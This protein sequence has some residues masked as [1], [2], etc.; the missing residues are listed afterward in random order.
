MKYADV[1]V[2]Y[3]VEGSFTYRVPEGMD[4]FPG[5][6]AR[7]NFK[8]RTVTAFVH[9]V[10]GE[11][12]A[13]KTKDIQSLIDPAPIFDE[14]FTA[15]CA[16]V[17]DNYFSS[18]GEAM[19][20]AL[21]S[22]QRP[23][24]RHE[25][26]AGVSAGALVLTE[27]QQAACDAIF[28]ARDTGER[29]HLVFGV[30]GSGKTE[31]Y[32]AL[33]RRVMDEGKSVIYLVPEISLSS[34]VFT[35][36]RGMFG[37]E[38]IVYHSMLTAN[39]RLHNWLK[40]M[41]GEARI[42]VGTRSAV[43]LQAPDLGLLII[44]EEHD[45]SYKEHSSPRYNARR[46]AFR[47]ARDEGALLV[48]GSATPSV[49]SLYAA[50]R[51]MMRLHMLRKRYGGATLPNIEIARLE[52]LS[53]SKMLSTPLLLGTTKALDE[54]GQAIFFLNRRG[55]A[56]FL[57]CAGCGAVQECPHCSISLNFHRDETLRC[58]YCGHSRRVPEV[59]P[60]C[61][62][63]KLEK[64]GTGTQRLEHAVEKAFAGRR[65]FRL[66]QDSARRKGTAGDLVA[67]MQ[68]GA[69]DIL[70]GT[71]M[72]AKGFDFHGVTL[73]GVI[74]ADVGLNIP[75]FRASE[76]IFSL[77]LQVAGRCGRGSSPGRVIIQ[78]LNGD[79]EIFEFL[80]RHDY[81]GFYRRELELR[82]A[83][84]YPPF[85]RLARLLARGPSEE[86]V[87]RT[88][89]EIAGALRPVVS[90]EG[91]GT[92]MLG[93]VEAPLAKIGGNFRHH[94]ILKSRDNEA[95]RRAITTAR[96]CVIP[97]NVYLEIDVDPVELM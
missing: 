37:N 96:A 4:A 12:P 76:R 87:A 91:S 74:L 43:F 72:V 32:M 7:V 22:G 41:R 8:N 46:V 51:G 95:L 5:M 48:M 14:R 78:T 45:G 9:R 60:S 29:A 85:S 2:G 49:E 24:A 89:Q 33:A 93:P 79:A 54:G 16:F 18:M 68:S 19:A 59:C 3:P 17:A 25:E 34:Q 82:K 92:V 86:R 94:I 40:F 15:L 53:P 58:H 97:H 6:R 55:F 20:M 83:C 47:R 50:E 81:A 90:A 28:A 27:E 26:D 56:P 23:S 30:T 42:A 31:L 38:L 57:I 35:R 80:V 62:D 66:D 61:G 77:L 70:L 1:Y 71:Q 39:Q 10:H 65:I 44:D 69:I 64:V 52:S 73:V 36:L 67:G 88:I 84:S 63:A 75:D 21:P 13:F 11:T